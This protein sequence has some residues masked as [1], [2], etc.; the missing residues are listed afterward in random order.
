MSGIGSQRPPTPC[1]L[2]RITI[3]PDAK[4]VPL[5]A[6]GASPGASELRPRFKKINPKYVQRCVKTERRTEP[7]TRGRRFT[8]RAA[9]L[10]PR[11]A[12]ARVR[13]VRV[14]GSS[15][16]SHAGPVPA[17]PAAA[18]SGG[19]SRSARAARGCASAVRSKTDNGAFFARARC[20]PP[21]R[22]PD[23]SASRASPCRAGVRP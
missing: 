9:R 3:R 6:D 23:R 15:T 5:T 14:V 16:S 21:R 20:A 19:G 4:A 7:G 17:V 1:A 11:R 10:A 13:R 22:P 8:A 18:R 2:S 12:A